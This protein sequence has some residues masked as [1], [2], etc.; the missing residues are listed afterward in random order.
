MEEGHWWYDC[1]KLIGLK[2]LIPSFL[3]L[4]AA[5][6]VRKATQKLYCSKVCRKDSF[7]WLATRYGR[8]D[9]GNATENLSSCSQNFLGAV[10]SPYHMAVDMSDKTYSPFLLHYDY[11][12]CK[13]TSNQVFPYSKT[14]TFYCYFWWSNR[15]LEILFWKHQ[16]YSI[17]LL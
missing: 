12:I 7:L 3:R 15:R 16:F 11:S 9:Y 10:I 5:G 14:F 8:Y 2:P 13:L 4:N 6:V 1:G 17:M